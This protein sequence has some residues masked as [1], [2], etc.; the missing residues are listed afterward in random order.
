MVTTTVK[1]EDT[2]STDILRG[3][4]QLQEQV[5]ATQLL[6]DQNQKEASLAAAHNTEVLDARL[7]AIEIALA[8]Q[9]ARELDATQSANRA[10]IVVAG[11]F[12]TV[13]FGAM[14]L[15]AYFQWRTVHSLAEVSAN[16]ASRRPL[17]AAPAV[18]A[19]GFDENAVAATG[20]AE[21]SS[22]RLLG[23]LG[24]LEK[25]I[26]QIEHSA[27]AGAAGSGVM[28]VGNGPSGSNGNGQTPEPDPKSEPALLA[29]AQ[30]LLDDGK[31][32]PAL[33]C[34]Q[35][36]LAIDP[37]SPEALVKK[38]SALERLQKFDEAVQ[39]Y[40]RAIALNGSMTIAYLAKGGLFNR[41]ERFSEALACYEQ[42]LHTQEKR[43]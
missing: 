12:A 21:E 1:A 34:I 18:A 19:L 6:I 8:A 13:G 30:S 5:H 43:V 23:A 39:C 15:M 41:M 31:L 10:M 32:E 25:R 14:L 17:G 7:Q 33:E 22:Q 24:Q 9:R 40:D 4:L 36:L 42:A 20:P 35:E 28:Q 26:Y 29:K 16:F 38:G 2:N 3:Y 27:R 37:D 11:V